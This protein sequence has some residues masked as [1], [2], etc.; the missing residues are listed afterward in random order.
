MWLPSFKV[1]TCII[2]VNLMFVSCW[3]QFFDPHP[4]PPPKRDIKQNTMYHSR[5]TFL[6]IRVFVQMEREITLTWVKFFLSF[7]SNIDQ[8]IKAKQ[9]DISWQADVLN[10]LHF[11]RTK[12]QFFI[13]FTL[14]YFLFN[15]MTVKVINDVDLMLWCQ[16]NLFFSAS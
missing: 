2:K 5:Q 13:F 8:T 6:S 14:S 7:S 15:T 12:T 9:I 16:R 10:S 11:K 4:P 3:Q 1:N